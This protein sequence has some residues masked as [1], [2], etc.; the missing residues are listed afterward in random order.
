MALDLDLLTENRTI[1]SSSLP[2]EARPVLVSF[3]DGVRLDIGPW[4]DRV[5]VVRADYDRIWELPV[6]GAVSAPG[7]VL[8]RPDGYIAWVGDGKRGHPTAAL[9]TWFGS[10]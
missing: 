8:I 7:A 3:G 4:T 9:Q 2:H 1:R 5:Q 6:L 10:R